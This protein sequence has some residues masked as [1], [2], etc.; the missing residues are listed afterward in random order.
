MRE[1]RLSLMALTLGFC[2]ILSVPL[3]ASAQTY[4]TESGEPFF[5][6]HIVCANVP[7]AIERAEFL[8]GYLPDIGI[9]GVVHPMPIDAFVNG[10]NAELYGLDQPGPAGAPS[11]VSVMRPG[12]GEPHFHHAEYEEEGVM[13]C[14]ADYPNWE[15]PPGYGNDWL[16]YL[17][18]SF[19]LPTGTVDLDFSIQY[20]TEFSYDFF[21]VEVTQDG[22]VSFDTILKLSGSS[23]WFSGI[24]WPWFPEWYMNQLEYDYPTLVDIENPDEDGFVVIH[25]DIS[26][27]A[28]ENVLIRFGF[29]SDTAW[30]DEDGNYDS[31]G[32]CRIDWVAVTE[33]PTDD[34]ESGADG[35]I[36]ASAAEPAYVDIMRGW[37]LALLAYSVSGYSPGVFS[38][39]A[40]EI[41]NEGYS[42]PKYDEKINRLDSLNI[43]WNANFPDPP[44][45]D[46][47]AL[48]TLEELQEIFVED[49]PFSVLWSRTYW[50]STG[51]NT[52]FPVLLYNFNN[53]HLVKRDV[54]QAI[55]MG[56]DRQEMMEA[57]AYDDWDLSVVQTPLPP[58]HPG[59]DKKFLP[60]YSPKMALRIIADAGYPEDGFESAFLL[61]VIDTK[62]FE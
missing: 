52:G 34:F 54:R 41:N 22:G 56:I 36:A 38:G 44:V 55:S 61:M 45:L 4:P 8:A 25:T 7:V 9:E 33:N 46:R 18:K 6:L 1:K 35:W 60:R 59:F 42:N 51:W 27:Y 12:T 47:V 13:W 50:F 3:L 11:I 21:F 49:Q 62:P 23:D 19:Q 2:L 28:G 29:S 5:T 30:S 10:L 15:T 48:D 43:A 14:G 17:T 58:Q 39:A 20:D 24:P 32:A 26:A 31:N 53:E 16:D 40:T 57:T 37:D